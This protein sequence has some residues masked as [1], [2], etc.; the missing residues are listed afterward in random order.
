VEVEPTELLGRERAVVV[1]AERDP[2]IAPGQLRRE[3]AGVA[4]A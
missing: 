2:S 4:G 1:A 3:P